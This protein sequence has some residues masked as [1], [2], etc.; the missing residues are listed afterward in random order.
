MK[1]R[2]AQEQRERESERETCLQRRFDIVRS[3]GQP[4]AAVSE[5]RLGQLAL[6]MKKKHQRSH[7]RVCVKFAAPRRRF[8]FENSPNS[9]RPIV[10]SAAGPRSRGFAVMTSD[11][12][13]TAEMSANKE[14]K[15]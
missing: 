7:Q 5:L 3:D 10:P 2:G 8:A 13:R 1:P 4:E 12:A 11:P 9:H 6:E 15:Q 14:D